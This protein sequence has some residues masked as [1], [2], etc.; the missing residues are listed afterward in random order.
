MI[1]LVALNPSGRALA[2]R[3]HAAWPDSSKVYRAMVGACMGPRE[4]ME[5][6]VAECEQ[7]VCFARVPAAVRLLAEALEDVARVPDVVCVDLAPRYAVPLADRTGG[8]DRGAGTGGAGTRGRGAEELAEEVS[9]VLGTRP[10]LTR[11]VLA[12]PASH[13][14]GPLDALV[15]HATRA[16]R[17]PGGRAAAEAVASGRPVRLESELEYP[18]PAL[19]PNV[20]PDAPTDAP[21]LRITDRTYPAEDV[22]L[23][24]PRTLVVGVGA[25]AGADDSEVA[26]LVLATLE[27]AGLSRNSVAQLATVESRTGHPAIRWAA[28][29]LGVPLVGYPAERLAAVEVPTRSGE[30]LAAVGT[31]SVAEAA[32]LIG[33]AGG[34]LLVPKRK[35]ALATAAVARRA[36]RGRLAVVGLGPG[37]RD[38][39]T[40]R[41]AAEL[42]RAS[43]VV[44]LPAVVE[45]ISDLLRPGTRRITRPTPADCTRAAEELAR[46]GGAVALAG[47]GDAAGYRP[48]GEGFELLRAPGLPLDPPSGAGTG[49]DSAPD[50]PS[51]GADS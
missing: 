24:Q 29:A 31:P 6:A 38:L 3:L 23:V 21:V 41:A 15:G 30:V 35:S 27:E 18:L 5:R 26:K 2:D 33:A 34:E 9:A 28:F 13:P 44:A 12:R 25:A 36:V 1:G 46:Q 7:V 50:Q 19:P 32:A 4:T 20:R 16:T 45:Q 48:T 11:P 49:T 43:A 47:P 40:P 8:A 17:G 14:V 37:A 39:L 42:R 51:A 22:L 10:V